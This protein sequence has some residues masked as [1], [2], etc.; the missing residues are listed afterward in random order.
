[1]YYHYRSCR[2][3]KINSVPLEQIAFA[4][5]LFALFM[6]SLCMAFWNAGPIVLGTE[7]NANGHIEYLCAGTGCESLSSFHWSDK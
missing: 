1:M 5:V 4:F 3:Y 7:M 6:A 2:R